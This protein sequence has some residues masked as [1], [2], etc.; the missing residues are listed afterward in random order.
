[1]GFGKKKQDEKSI[2]ELM[3]DI[4]RY[5]EWR[6][7]PNRS[8]KNS[9][10]YKEISE[11]E[12]M[13]QDAYRRKV[14][15][16]LE[17]QEAFVSTFRDIILTPLAPIFGVLSLVSK[18]AMYVGAATFLFA[19]YKVYESVRVGD[20]FWGSIVAECR[21]LILPFIA[22]FLY[23]VFSQIALYCSDHSLY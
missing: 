12:R 9:P 22:S 21:F 23:F 7:D 4:Q 13:I 1:M 3:R 17:M 15:R 11:E 18:I 20:S 10:F 16:R 8:Y 5:K 19:C 14:E 6:K 2:D